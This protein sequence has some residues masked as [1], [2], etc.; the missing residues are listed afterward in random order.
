MTP[1]QFKQKRKELNLSQK[2]LANELGLATANGDR[3]IRG[4]ETGSRKPSKLLVRCFELFYNDEIK[5]KK[6]KKY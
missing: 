2:E 5:A 3:Q 6:S 4:I 1:Q